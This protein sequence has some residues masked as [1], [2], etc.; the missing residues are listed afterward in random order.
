MSDSM[1]HS[2]ILNRNDP[3]IV[4]SQRTIG[5]FTLRT[6]SRHA[7]EPPNPSADY[8][9]VVIGEVRGHDRRTKAGRPRIRGASYVSLQIACVEFD[10]PATYSGDGSHDNSRG[11]VSSGGMVGACRSVLSSGSDGILA[12]PGKE[13]SLPRLFGAPFVAAFYTATFHI[14]AVR[15]ANA[16]LD[17]LFGAPLMAASF[18]SRAMCDANNSL[19]G[20]VS[21]PLVAAH[22]AFAPCVAQTPPFLD[23]LAHP[24][25]LHR[26]LVAPCVTQTPTLWAPLAHPLWLNCFLV[27][28]Y[29]TQ[30]PPLKGCLAH[31]S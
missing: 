30:M 23:P 18:L 25:W 29:V 28:L 19:L 7:T 2:S 11:V 8:I 22:F 17:G 26:F 3:L 4:P 31:P 12:M 14:R 5:I 21:A 10:L 9:L 27:A 20:S 24:L 1:I 13:S 15:D 16:S 6:E